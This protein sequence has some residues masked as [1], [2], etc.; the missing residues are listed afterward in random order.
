M[1]LPVQNRLPECCC[2]VTDGLP[3]G[4]GDPITASYLFRHE[5]ITQFG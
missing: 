4:K 2:P 1:L 5:R 3:A